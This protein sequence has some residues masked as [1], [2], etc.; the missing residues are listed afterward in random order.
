MKRI[1][2]MFM[3]AL[4]LTAIFSINVVSLAWAQPQEATDTKQQQGEERQ[5]N[6]PQGEKHTPQKGEEPHGRP[7][8]EGPHTLPQ[9]QNILQKKLARLTEQRKPYEVVLRG[10]RDGDSPH[11]TNITID[12]YGFKDKK[13]PVTISPQQNAGY[14]PDLFVGDFLGNGTQQILLSIQSGGS[15]A[16]GYY[17]IYSFDGEKVSVL[18]DFE[19]FGKENR[20]TAKYLD[21]YKVQ[22]EGLGK[23]YLIDLSQRDKSYLNE[24]YNEDGT[25]KKPIDGNVSD[26]N[27]LYPVYNNQTRRFDLLIYQRITG[28]YNAD[29]LGYVITRQAYSSKGTFKNIFVQVGINGY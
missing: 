22:V 27:A 9:P 17:Y 7:K 4:I 14:G 24:I 21:N 3:A 20:Y 23:R 10:D 1:I 8:G 15:G 16:F 25:L 5:D 19:N 11:V 13:A 26:L 28:L 2:Y 18:F 29:G 12:I 6:V